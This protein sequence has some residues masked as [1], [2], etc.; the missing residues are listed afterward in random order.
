MSEIDNILVD[1]VDKASR[2]SILAAAR[3]CDMKLDCP[4]K[5]HDI[6]WCEFCL[7]MQESAN[8]IKQKILSLLREQK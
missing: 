6:R 2:M 3:M 7:A 4:S 1:A 8:Q 5:N